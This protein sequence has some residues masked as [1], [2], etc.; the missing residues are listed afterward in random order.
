ML[1]VCGSSSSSRMP[2]TNLIKCIVDYT[3]TVY[4]S[5]VYYE[6]YIL[7]SSCCAIT[8]RFVRD[9]IASNKKTACDVFKRYYSRISLYCNVYNV[10]TSY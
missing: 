6:I 2:F 3:P 4:G 8:L 7:Y 5:R 1:N 9:D 10:Y